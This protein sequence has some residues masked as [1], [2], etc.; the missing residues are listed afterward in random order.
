MDNL[1]LCAQYLFRRFKNGMHC[2]SCPLETG[3]LLM[4]SIDNHKMTCEARSRR[5]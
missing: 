4:L 3:E 5:G 1:D 2:E